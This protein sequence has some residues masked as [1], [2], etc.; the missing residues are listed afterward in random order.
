M[1]G[2]TLLEWRV[3]VKSGRGCLEVREMGEG[4]AGRAGKRALGV[5][6]EWRK[7]EG[8]AQGRRALG[9]A[10]GAG[11]ARDDRSRAS[12]KFENQGGKDP[13]W[14]G[15]KPG[16]CGSRHQ[17]QSGTEV[18]SIRPLTN[19]KWSLTQPTCSN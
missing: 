12:A 18:G 19:T 6:R 3:C 4:A 9:P 2:P 8:Y 16:P 14:S 5:R 7:R 15:Q 11:A 10:L 17:V 1:K 13:G